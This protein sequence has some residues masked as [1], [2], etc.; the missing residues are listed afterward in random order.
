MF[1]RSIILMVNVQHVAS[2]AKDLKN[3]QALITDS[4]MNDGST[5]TGIDNTLAKLG[6]FT[7]S[8]KLSDGSDR[9]ALNIGTSADAQ[10][11]FIPAGEDYDPPTSEDHRHLYVTGSNGPIKNVVITLSM[12]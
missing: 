7:I 6:S 11:L 4:F 2:E 12:N 8:G 9:P 5:T 3:L 1:K 10:P